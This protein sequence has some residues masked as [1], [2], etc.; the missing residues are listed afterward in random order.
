[1]KLTRDRMRAKA[2]D[3]PLAADYLTDGGIF[4]NLGLSAIPPVAG[5]G[6]PPGPFTHILVSDASAGFDWEPDDP[7]SGIVSRTSRTTDILMQRVASL[8]AAR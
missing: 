4:D 7:L 2:Q 1:M 8:E 5:A 3:F 6:S